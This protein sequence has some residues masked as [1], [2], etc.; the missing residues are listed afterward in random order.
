VDHPFV[1]SYFDVG[2]VLR[3]GYPQHWIRVLGARI[4]KVHFKDYRIDVGTID[5]FVDLLS[6]DV[7]YPAV[8]EALR[9]VGYDGWC[10]AEIGPRPRWPE[11]TLTATARAMDL[12]LGRSAAS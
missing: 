4:K 9:D 1:G 3:T 2:N 10:I 6:G 7:D 8:I 5:G 11:S 12:I